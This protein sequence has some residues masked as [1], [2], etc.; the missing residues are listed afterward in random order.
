MRLSRLTLLIGTALL[1]LL[2][3]ASALANQSL[4]IASPTGFPAGG[5]PSYT[6]TI[7]LDTGSGTPSNVT[8]SLAPG[9]LASP[10]ANPSCLKTAQQT[11]SC[12]I[13]TGSVATSLPAVTVPLTA[14]LAPPPNKGDVVGIDIVPGLPGLPVTHAG[15]MLVQ[16]ASG[17]V[18]TVLSLSLS[19]L[20]PL[21]QSV[22]GISL[23]VNG[24][25]DG[26]PF[27]RMPTNCSPGQS[28]LSVVYTNLTDLVTASPDFAPT[29]CATLPYAPQATAT[30]HAIPHVAAGTVVQT[31]TQA[32]GQAASSKTTLSLPKSTLLPNIGALKYQNTSTPVGSAVAATPLL[33]SPL[34][35]KIFLKGTLQ[36][37]YLVFTFPPPAALTL[38]GAVNLSSDSVTIP[39]V[40]DV[41]L[42]RLQVTF[43]GGPYGLLVV[44]CPSTPAEL[45]GTFV[46][47]NG[48]TATSKHSV[49][50]TGCTAKSG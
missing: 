49:T 29:G 48:K 30:A 21:A 46:G 18:Q 25:L 17:N 39:V 28:T 8:L 6:T 15:A 35:G 5:D 50:V 24:T 33:P 20:G 44:G 37:P 14:Y 4:A 42:T 3:P 43:P 45:T 9:V 11:A 32:P 2:A 27:N 26:K 19:G 38:T 47:Q 34:R 1:A 16:T 36:K 40:P 7:I 22:T 13:G 23:T 41:P 31:I 10:S 12:E